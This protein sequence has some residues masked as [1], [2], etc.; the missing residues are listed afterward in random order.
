MCFRVA[1]FVMEPLTLLAEAQVAS[2]H[3]GAPPQSGQAAHSDVGYSIES[4]S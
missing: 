4:A 3:S 1:Q 2:K